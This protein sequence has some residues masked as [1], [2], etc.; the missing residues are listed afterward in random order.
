[1][2]AMPSTVL[3]IEDS[4]TFRALLSSMLATQGYSV[5]SAENGEAGIRK[6]AK[7]RPNLVILDLSLPGMSGVEVLS[8]LKGTPATERIPVI[9]CTA[10]VDGEL[11]QEVQQRGADAIFTK[12]VTPKDLFVALRNHLSASPNTVGYSGTSPV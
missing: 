5:I 6:A 12:P 3:L 4:A 10:S 11:R 2:A 1:M 9:I 8:A 7:E